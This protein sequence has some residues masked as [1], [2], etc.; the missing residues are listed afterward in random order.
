MAIFAE[1]SIQDLFYEVEES[2]KQ[3]FE[4]IEP[5]AIRG[6][7]DDDLNHFASQFMLDELRIDYENIEFSDPVEGTNLF[8]DYDSFDGCKRKHTAVGFFVKFLIPVE[9][10]AQ[11]LRYFPLDNSP[12]GLYLADE[13]YKEIE[14]KNELGKT[15]LSFK[16]FFAKSFLDECNL[17]EKINNEVSKFLTGT[18][19][20]ELELNSNVHSFNS[21]I[22]EFVKQTFDTRKAKILYK[23]KLSDAIKIHFIPRN[24]RQEMGKKMAIKPKQVDVG[25]SKRKQTNGFYIDPTDFRSILNT[26][27]FHLTATEENPR[28]II[29]LHNE[30]L[31]RDTILWALNANYFVA[32][33]ETF[34]NHGKTDILI[35]FNDRS[36][37]IAECKVWNG[38]ESLVKAI[39]QLLSYTTWRDS[40]CAI[41]VFNL[42]VHDFNKVYLDGM[43]AIQNHSEFV[44]TIY[45]E[46]NTRELVCIFKD[47]HNPESN[48]EIA[49]FFA[50]YVNRI[51]RL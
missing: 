17:D 49:F 41:I 51:D 42:N 29:E 10:G 4:E 7:S 13:N 28:A 40:K 5:N 38:K 31:I 19:E 32:T 12:F 21:Q 37:F 33:G 44:K 39:D 6:M 2:I 46:E 22:P 30:E 45:S 15:F 24:E 14:L 3:K 48:L 23:N 35:S 36:A 1:K 18:K 50:N 16:L 11:Y 20:L 34:R 47:K 27:K 43:D 25:L 8:F 9:S 26:I